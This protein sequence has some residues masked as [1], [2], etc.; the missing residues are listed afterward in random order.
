MER[1]R[2]VLN[3][4]VESAGVTYGMVKMG[5]RVLGWSEMMLK[6]K[7]HVGCVGCSRCA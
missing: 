1:T 3:R 2:R 7:G 6:V 5:E 4:V